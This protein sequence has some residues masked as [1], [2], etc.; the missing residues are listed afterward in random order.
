[1]AIKPQNLAAIEEPST[2][3]HC[4]TVARKMSKCGLC[5]KVKFCS[6][7]CQ[8]AGRAAHKEA[9]KQARAGQATV[10]VRTC[11]PP[12]ITM[13]HSSAAQHVQMGK[14]KTTI[15]KIQV[16]LDFEFSSSSSSADD[17]AL[18]VYNCQRDVDFFI[19]PRGCAEYS[20][21]VSAVKSKGVCG[22]KAFFPAMLHGDGK[23][24]IDFCNVLPPENW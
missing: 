16:P 22:R 5:F 15:V 23:I 24:T 1:M 7:E 12:N 14:T 8:E 9:C 2:C 20:A 13:P 11:G 6:A 19:S 4:K 10:D 21:I 18:M 3:S 17:E